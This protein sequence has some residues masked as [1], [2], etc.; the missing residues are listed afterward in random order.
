ME[1]H[2]LI[3][4]LP[5]STAVIGINHSDLSRANDI[6]GRGKTICCLSIEKVEKV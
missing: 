4:K 6:P 5:H 2:R 1:G 3:E